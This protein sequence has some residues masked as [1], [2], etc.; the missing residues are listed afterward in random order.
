MSGENGEYGLELID[1][2]SLIKPL[3]NSFNSGDSATSE[4]GQTDIIRREK[5]IRNMNSLGS[6]DSQGTDDTNESENEGEDG[7]DNGSRDYEDDDEDSDDDNDNDAILL[8]KAINNLFGSEGQLE[9]G[10]QI[11]VKI[12]DSQD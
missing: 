3:F 9:G 8:S 4:D 6:L 11:K 12:K 7:E 5:E 2:L 1:D 10:N